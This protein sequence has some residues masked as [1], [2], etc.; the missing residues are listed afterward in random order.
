MGMAPSSSQT[1]KFFQQRAMIRY[2]VQ[3]SEELGF[4]ANPW[5]SA[6]V[7]HP[8]ERLLK[9]GESMRN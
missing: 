6:E 8:R 1:K 4:S 7:F 9:K 5:D 3:E 2:V